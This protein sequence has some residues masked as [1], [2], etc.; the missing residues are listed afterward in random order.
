MAR[1]KFLGLLLAASLLTVAPASQAVD[2]KGVATGI[3]KGS[4]YLVS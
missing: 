1:S 3:S 2:A 4:I